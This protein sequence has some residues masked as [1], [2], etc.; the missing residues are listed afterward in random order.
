M[1]NYALK[2]DGS[3]NYV[4]IASNNLMNVSSLTIAFRV[5][6]T[7]TIQSGSPQQQ[8]F[9]RD[10]PIII[11]FNSNGK[12]EFALNGGSYQ[13]LISNQAVW[14]AGTQYSC[15]LTYDRPST[16]RNIYING[17][18][19][20][21]DTSAINL[22]TTSN[23]LYLGTNG[24]SSN[25]LNATLDD[26]RFYARALSASEVLAYGAAAGINSTNLILWYK[27]DDGT[28]TTLT[29]SSGNN[30]NGV[31]HGSPPPSWVTGLENPAIS[32]IGFGN[33]NPGLEGMFG[34]NQLN[35]T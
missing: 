27:M 20:N 9:R 17:V 35:L 28:G 26:V 22:L 12:L 7:L 31:L 2:F 1:A 10:T 11:D 8:V 3:Q 5:I 4:Q 19:D 18:V 15:V 30:I 24:G 16:L 25:F 23:T 34:G 21:H 13:T 29:D 32:S 33:F 6:P 14:T